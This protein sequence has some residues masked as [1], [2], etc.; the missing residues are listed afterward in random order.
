MTH[1]KKKEKLHFHQLIVHY[2]TPTQQMLACTFY[3]YTISKYYFLKCKIRLSYNYFKY[4][5]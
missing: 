5:S 2:K 1:F 4:I 3:N